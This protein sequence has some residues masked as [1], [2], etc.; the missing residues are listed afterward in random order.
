MNKISNEYI[1]N[2]NKI[3]G[4][5]DST[6]KNLINKSVNNNRSFKEIFD[7]INRNDKVNFSKHALQRLEKRNINLTDDDIN[8]IS[9][10]VNKA[11]DKGIKDALI[12]LG[13]NA[14]V[15]SIKNNMVITAASGKELKENVFTNID[16]AVII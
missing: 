6:K 13:D 11:K 9:D 2:R 10:A 7:K 12:I 14:F 4:V 5:N 16:G 3:N 15:T 8:K 1:L